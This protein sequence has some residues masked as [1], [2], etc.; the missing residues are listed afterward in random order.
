[1]RFSLL[2]VIFGDKLAYKGASKIFNLSDTTI[3]TLI[4]MP[5]QTSD[6]RTTSERDV[7]S[8]SLTYH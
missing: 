3:L 1:M 2:S 6:T 7:S 5:P 4:H 8:T